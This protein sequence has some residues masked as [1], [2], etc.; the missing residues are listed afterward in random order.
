MKIIYRGKNVETEA[1]SIREYL[2]N[3][4]GED[5][6]NAPA[7]FV[8]GKI[9]ELSTELK[10]GMNNMVPEGRFLLS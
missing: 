7:A 5:F 9:V 1:F 3:N 2:K 4:E 10:D 8:D 6:A